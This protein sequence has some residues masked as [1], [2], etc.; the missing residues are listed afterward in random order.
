[1]D[2]KRRKTIRVKRGREE[3]TVVEAVFS[4]VRGPRRARRGTAKSPGGDGTA[5]GGP[6][7]SGEPQDGGPYNV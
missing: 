2:C 3:G 1:V 5:V 6:F 7:S 4:T